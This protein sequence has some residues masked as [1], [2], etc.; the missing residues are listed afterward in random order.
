MLPASVVRM[1]DVCC[2]HPMFEPCRTCVAGGTADFTARGTK[3][4]AVRDGCRFQAFPIRW[5]K[6]Y[7][8]HKICPPS[9]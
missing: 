9:T 8:R 6:I 3:L 2:S 5:A 7:H 4:D 1:T